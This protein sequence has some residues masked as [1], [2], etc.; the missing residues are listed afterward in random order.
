MKIMADSFFSRFAGR[1][2]WLAIVSLGVLSLSA[3][4]LSAQDDEIFDPFAPE[5]RA[6]DSLTEGERENPFARDDGASGSEQDPFE[7][8]RIG[9]TDS[10]DGEK[11]L[12]KASPESRA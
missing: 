4:D 1:V 9:T 11:T 6:S 5:G 8:D 3:Q 10:P 12:M 7:T 2:G